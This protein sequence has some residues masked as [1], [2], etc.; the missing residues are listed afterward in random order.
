VAGAEV[1]AAIRGDQDVDSGA[2]PATFAASDWPA[3]IWRW[4]GSVA[5][6]DLLAD[7]DAPG[8]L[9]TIATAPTEGAAVRVAVDGATVAVAPALTGNTIPV[10]T[11]LG[12]GAH[13]VQVETV[14]GGRVA[15]GHV[16]LLR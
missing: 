15:P 8:L 16:R 2:D 3:T 13:L 14:A 7:R 6:A 12:S 9:V 4:R 5:W 10:A 11:S 1:R